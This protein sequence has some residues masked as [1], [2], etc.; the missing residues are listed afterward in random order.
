MKIDKLTEKILEIVNN[1]DYA[2]I[3][4]DSQE[5]D[6]IRKLLGE[7]KISKPVKRLSSNGVF[8]KCSKCNFEPQMESETDD[9]LRMNFCPNCGSKFK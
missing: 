2:R 3:D 5:A 4:L 9:L 1:S 7:Y 6:K 8:F